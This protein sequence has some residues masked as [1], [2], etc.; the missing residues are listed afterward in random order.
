MIEVRGARKKFCRNLRYSMW[1]GIRNLSRDLLGLPPP[2]VG[3]RKYEFW[4]LDDVSFALQR[5][6]V[7]GL[8]GL[9][10]CGKTS[11][12]RLLTGIFP[13]D[14]GHIT[15]RGRVGALIALGAGF[16]PDMTGRENIYLNGSILGIEH[17][18]IEAKL[19]E[20]IAF[21][22]IGPFID[23]PVSHYSSGMRVRLGFS[24][25]TALKPDILLI[26]EVLTVGDVRF[27]GKCYNLMKQLARETTIVF[28]SHQMPQ[29]SLLCNK[30]CFLNGGKVEYFGDDVH[31]GIDLYLETSETDIGAVGGSGKATFTD[32]AI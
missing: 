8:I 23:A 4:A 30:V 16:H 20:I 19:D 11:L 29:I 5:G 6:D 2:G 28:V 3:L 22:E 24:V 9:N 18:E 26:D 12:L 10:G 27:R 21:A 14:E 17:R 13:P 15:M 1:Y 32:I 7:L 25:A 31:R